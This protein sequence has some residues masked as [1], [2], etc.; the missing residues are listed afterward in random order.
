MDILAYCIC[1][2]GGFVI[3]IAT[4]VSCFKIIDKTVEKAIGEDKE[5]EP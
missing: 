2:L 5:V 4:A 1:S 3:G